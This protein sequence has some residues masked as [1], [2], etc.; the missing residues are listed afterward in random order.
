MCDWEETRWE[1]VGRSCR[2]RLLERELDQG[3]LCF[4]LGLTVFDLLLEGVFQ[5]V[6]GSALYLRRSPLVVVL[7]A[8]WSLQASCT[9]HV[10]PKA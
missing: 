10:G 7:R 1:G 9:R 2:E 3:G 5:G 6:E 4:V 8:D